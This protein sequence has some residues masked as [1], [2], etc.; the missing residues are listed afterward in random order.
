MKAISLW[1][2]WATL[3]AIRAKR[4]ETRSWSTD[5]R[6]VLAIHAAKRFTR[7]QR[8]YCLREPFRTAL[9]RVGIMHWNKLVPTLGHVL[10]IGVLADCQQ[11][12]RDIVSLEEYTNED[13]AFGDWSDGRS[14]W[15]L[16]D[17]ARL[18]LAV[19][20]IGSQRFWNWR[21][22]SGLMVELPNGE[23]LEWTLRYG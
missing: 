9:A 18:T 10:A 15:T 23:E 11:V 8:D 22:P 21:S 3:I 6:G 17:V 14:V 2:P 13:L 4:F 7:D 20:A 1:E 12:G 16:K 5:Y 19:P